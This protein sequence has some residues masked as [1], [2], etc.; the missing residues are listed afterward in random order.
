MV[1]RVTECM[2]E[3]ELPLP[4]ALRGRIYL[5]CA[6]VNGGLGG[7]VVTENVGRA[8]VELPSV[9]ASLLSIKVQ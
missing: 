2:C 5:R 7:R 8:R 6:G 1:F 4:T 3:G 9:P